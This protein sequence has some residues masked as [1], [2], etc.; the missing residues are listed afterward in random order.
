[1]RDFI[2]L[3]FEAVGRPSCTGGVREVVRLVRT[4]KPPAVVVVA[5]ADAAGHRGAGSL[6]SALLPYVVCLKVIEPPA[7]YKDLRAWK[8]A[9]ATHDDVA[10]LIKL[11]PIRDLKICVNLVKKARMVWNGR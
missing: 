8:K 3:G 7:P 11:A 9:G 2:D 1:M 6:A 10:G 5:D 4:R